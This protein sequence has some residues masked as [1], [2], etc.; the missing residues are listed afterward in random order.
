M[1]L[2]AARIAVPAEA[3]ARCAPGA[4]VDLFVRPEQLRIAGG[5]D[6]IAT[7]GIVAA[8]VYQGGHV[9]LHVEVPEAARGRLVLRLPGY[10]AIARWPAGTQV[11]IA[12]GDA[13]TV[14]FPRGKE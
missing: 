5:A 11:A 9:D 3:L 4:P 14:A 10:D 8:H 7:E 1:A 6:P 12:V 2:G 13:D